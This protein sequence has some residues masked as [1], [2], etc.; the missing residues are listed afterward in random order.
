MEIVNDYLIKKKAD[1][2]NERKK[3]VDLNVEL[4]HEIDAKNQLNQIRIQKKVKEH[5]SEEIQ[6]LNDKLNEHNEKIKDQEENM[7]RQ[8]GLIKK[9]TNEIIQK[10]IQLKHFEE[11]REELS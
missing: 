8:L 6:N 1:V 10:K 7:N 4:R 2:I 3:Y 11:Q 5:N 9:Y